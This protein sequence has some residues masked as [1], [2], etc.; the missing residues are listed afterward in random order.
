MRWSRE[1]SCPSSADER[2]KE[3]PLLGDEIC[4]RF[5]NRAIPAEK[6]CWLVSLAGEVDVEG[7][8]EAT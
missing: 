1:S 3:R 8:E 2:S 7:H 4:G 5:G 6:R